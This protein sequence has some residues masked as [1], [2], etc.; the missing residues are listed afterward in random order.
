MVPKR[1]QPV[2]RDDIS[3]P[4]LELFRGATGHRY[5]PP[6]TR[7]RAEIISLTVLGWL[8][9]DEDALTGFL[10]VSGADMATLRSGADNP[11][12][13]LAVTEYL[14][15]QDALAQRF[16]ETTETPPHDLHQARHMLGGVS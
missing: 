9:G 4:P 16:C 15:S 5:N 13:L 3:I 11:D 7:E 12:L 14:L 8:A 6:M 1:E 10:A 2:G